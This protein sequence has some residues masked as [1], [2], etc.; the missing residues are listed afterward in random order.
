MS[1]GAPYAPRLILEFV[2]EVILQDLKKVYTLTIGQRH[3]PGPVG[4]P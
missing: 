2:A 3:R 1:P 4:N